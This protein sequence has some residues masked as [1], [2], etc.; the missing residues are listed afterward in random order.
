MIPTNWKEGVVLVKVLV[1]DNDCILAAFI[2]TVL[3]DEGYVVQTARNGQEG[4]DRAITSP[5]DVIFLDLQMPVM[6][7]WTCY[8]RLKQ[9]QK[10]SSIPIIVMSGHPGGVAVQADLGADFFLS[11][12]F[13]IEDVIRVLILLVKKK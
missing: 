9:H 1:V 3:E 5:P 4:L 13:G 11:K 7:G 6:D 12:P 8:R 2:K 10:T